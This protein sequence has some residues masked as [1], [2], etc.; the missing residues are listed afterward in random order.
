[1]MFQSLVAFTVIVSDLN[2]VA[3]AGIAWTQ[4]TTQA[5]FDLSMK[6]SLAF[7]SFIIFV[8]L[9]VIFW[10]RRH[11]AVRALRASNGAGTVA[12]TMRYI[13]C[14]SVNTVAELARIYEEWCYLGS[15]SRMGRQWS[16]YRAVFGQYPCD[17]GK[18][19]WCV[20]LQKLAEEIDEMQDAGQVETRVKY[21]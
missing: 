9:I 20:A 15:R 16:G 1:M 8:W 14:G 7:T 4:A 17:D 19:R 5:S 6:F 3:V 12:G 11:H 10:W 2:I 21:Y 18:V 13:S